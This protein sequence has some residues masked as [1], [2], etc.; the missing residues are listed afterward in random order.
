MALTGKP[1]KTKHQVG[2]TVYFLVDGTINS[3][4]VVKTYALVS[5]PAN[6]STGVQINKYLIE[7]FPNTFA[8]SKLYSSKNELLYSIKGG[9][10]NDWSGTGVIFIE[11]LGESSDLS[12]SDFSGIDFSDA[13]PQDFNEAI[14][15]GSSFNGCN[16]TDC[17]LTNC[18]MKNADL[19]ST[20]L[21]GA[22]FSGA[23]LTG[24]LFSASADSKAEFK[25]A[26]GAGNYN[27]TTTIWTDGTA[28]GA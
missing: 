14:L 19:R 11:T 8:E 25:T 26:V 4:A 10:L 24:A 21:T 6:D 28:I 27:A 23:D 12:Y 18:T 22:D 2:S 15:D 13:N 1:S 9:Y 3:G 17:D 7:G 16:L 20:T 5:D